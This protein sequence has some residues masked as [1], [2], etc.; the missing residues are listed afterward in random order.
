MSRS[1]GDYNRQ[2]SDSDPQRHDIKLPF[3]MALT[4]KHSFRISGRLPDAV[5]DRRQ[6]TS[7]ER[8]RSDTMEKIWWS[9]L[10]ASGGDTLFGTAA[11]DGSQLGASCFDVY[12]DVAKQIP[13]IRAIDPSGVLV[14]RGVHDPHDYQ[15]VYRFW[16]VSLAEARA[17][18]RG[19]TF[20]GTDIDVERMESTSKRGDLDLVTLC[21]MCDR[22]RCVTFC[23]GGEVPLE[24]YEHNYGFVPYVV[25]PNIG[26]YRDVFG[27]ADYEM[28]R[29]LSHYISALFSREA[30]IL[31]MVANGAYQDRGSGQSVQAVNQVLRKG[32]VLPSK[33]DAQGIEPIDPPEVPDFEGPHAERALQFLKMLGFAPD[34]AW[35]DGG[36]GSG[37]DRGLQLQP[38]LEFTSMKQTNWTA[39]LARLAEMVFR[40]IED[41]Q[42]GT[43]TYRG[44]RPGATA[45]QSRAFAPF[46]IGPDLPS[47][48]A[49]ETVSDEFGDDLEVDVEL[50]RT[51]KELFGGDYEMRFVWQNRIDP[52]DPAF[53][54]AELNK[55][56]QG[57][58]SLETTLDRLGVQFPEDEMKR[59]EREAERFPW[60]RQGMIALVQAQIQAQNQNGEGGGGGGRPTDVAGGVM[61]ALQMMQTPDGSALDAD[62]GAAAMPGGLGPYTGGA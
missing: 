15:R 55:F 44:A 2:V 47:L 24:E 27:W 40:M 50:P 39:G 19:K 4:V 16:Q 31:R 21:Q 60:L 29:D 48:T 1:T 26:P 51:P 20:A 23:L 37:S 38:L 3:G 42:L 35:G 41:K 61:D 46:Q 30:D 22:E 25:I 28:V 54:L 62:A 34:A 13:L 9:I 5:V 58:Q 18:W 49:S 45:K 52:D 33:R 6:E 59:I 12:F 43:V 7:Q 17:Q 53:V 32:G 56:V 8:Y 10:R 14:V 57:A 36:A 11:W